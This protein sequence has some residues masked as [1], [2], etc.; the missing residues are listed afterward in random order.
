MPNKKS[1][2]NQKRPKKSK[3][4]AKRKQRLAPVRAVVPRFT[5]SEKQRQYTLARFDPFN[6]MAEGARNPNYSEVKTTA[7]AIRDQFTITSGAAGTLCGVGVKPCVSAYK[8]IFNSGTNLWGAL[9]SCPGY[10]NLNATYSA[11]RVVGGGVRLRC[12]ANANACQG[13]VFIGALSDTGSGGTGNWPTTTGGLLLYPEYSTFT[14]NQLNQRAKV[15]HFKLADADSLVFHL[16][17]ITHSDGWS[18]IFILV[19]GAA[20]TTDVI[21]VE[22]ILHV[23]CQA[24]LGIGSPVDYPPVD[25]SFFKDH[26]QAIGRDAP[27]VMDEAI[28]S[29][30]NKVGT[31]LIGGATNVATA[32]AGELMRRQFSRLLR[33]TPSNM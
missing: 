18:D 33:Q 1:N 23:E 5:P 9:A 10:A 13:E 14:I 17:S 15:A 21:S 22:V 7:F 19:S 24:T 2:K 31:G 30:A 4:V 8:S 28:N 29:F 6:D 27:L 20:A 16:P 25:S 26:V 32:F 3:N 11:I 12:M